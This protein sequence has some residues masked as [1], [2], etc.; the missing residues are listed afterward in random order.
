[1]NE[2][3]IGLQAHAALICKLLTL[4]CSALDRAVCFFLSDRVCPPFASWMPFITLRSLNHC[5]AFERERERERER[6]CVCV[7]GGGFA[8]GL[9]ALG[10]AVAKGRVSEGDG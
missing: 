10:G 7:C 8:T 2:K 4:T 6:M 9:A 3:R 5:C 1:M